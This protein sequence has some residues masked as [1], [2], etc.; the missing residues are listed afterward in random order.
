MAR[1]VIDA[2]AVAQIELA[3]SVFLDDRLGPL[4]VEDAKRYAPKRTGVMAALI[5]HSVDGDTLYIISPAPY[6]AWV[7]LG[8]RVFHPSTGNVG[9]EVVLEEPFLR[10]ALYKYRT[11]MVPDPPAT[12][13]TAVSHPGISYPNLFTYE[14]FHLHWRFDH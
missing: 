9:P 1:V 14:E 7:E 2:G 11:P 5:H 12:M 8:H 13:N 6:S 4:I 10:P 3:G